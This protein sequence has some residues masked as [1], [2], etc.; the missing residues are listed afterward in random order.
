MLPPALLVVERPPP[1]AEDLEADLPPMVP[2]A[3]TG[4]TGPLPKDLGN[5]DEA[6]SVT[7]Q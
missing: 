1:E 3:K 2:L 6:S 5:G 4:G 7:I